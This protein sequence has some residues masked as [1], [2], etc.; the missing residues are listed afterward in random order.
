MTQTHDLE[1]QTPGRIPPGHIDAV[2]GAA[3]AAGAGAA[4][5]SAA[6]APDSAA[7]IG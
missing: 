6:D 2:A 7:Q 4:D 5:G 1:K 3:G